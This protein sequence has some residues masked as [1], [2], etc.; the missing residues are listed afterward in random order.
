M[1]FKK[2]IIYCF[3]AIFFCST[4]MPVK[5]LA[6]NNVVLISAASNIDTKTSKPND[7]CK[8]KI[9]DDVNLG[10]KTIIAKDSTLEGKIVKVKKTSLLRSD[11]YID[12]LITEISTNKGNLNIQNDKIKMRIADSRYKDLNK[13][14]V[15][16]TPAYAASYATSI[17]LSSATEYA[18]GIIFVITLGATILAGFTSGWI[19]PDV[20][21]PKLQGAFIRCA[22][23]T[24]AGTLLTCVQCGYDVNCGKNCFLSVRFDR[25]TREKLASLYENSYVS[26]R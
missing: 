24:P 1:K 12:V 16:R 14:I 13:R 18:G 5:V 17:A 15:Q 11:A 9:M 23:G 2:I 3:L 20:G 7:V 25:K 21:C 26:G 4:T 22:E 10:N 6:E 8:F 19:D